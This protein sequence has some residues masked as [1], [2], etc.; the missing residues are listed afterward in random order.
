MN[1]KIYNALVT[2]LQ[3]TAMRHLMELE[4]ILQA[5]SSEGAVG[6]AGNIAYALVQAEG[7]LLTVQQY[8]QSQANAAEDSPPP[9]PPE[10]ATDAPAEK[11]LKITEEM[12]PTYRKSVES[13]KIKASARKSRKKDA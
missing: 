7:A 2:Q 9:P 13:E 8:F 11:P 12:S 4:A 10:I 3:A 6:R 1:I 5:P